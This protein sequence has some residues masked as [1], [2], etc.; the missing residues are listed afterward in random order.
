MKNK[1]PLLAV[2]LWVLCVQF[3]FAQSRTISGVVQDSETGESLPGVAVLEKGTQNGTATNFDG[4]FELTV[5]G[6]NVTLVFKSIGMEDKEVVLGTEDYIIVKMKESSESLDEVVVTAL[7]VSKEKRSLGYTAATVSSDEITEGGDRSPLNSMQGK[8]AGVNISSASSSP[9]SS[10]RI[11]IRGLQSISQNNQP[12]FVIDG[13]PIFNNSSNINSLNNGADFGNG[14]NA[15]NPEDIENIS[16]LKG[17]SATA[18][19]G[20]RAAN[21]VVLITTKKGKTAPAGKKNFGISYAGNVTFSD[22]YILPTFQEDFGQGWDG[23]HLLGENGSWGPKYDGQERVWGNVVDNSQLLKPFVHLPDNVRDFF[24]TGVS[25]QNSISFNGG[26]EKGSYYVSFSNTKSDGIYPTDVDSYNRNTVALRGSR[27]EGLFNFSGSFN[28]TDTRS[29]FVPT[30]QGP[31]VYNNIMQIPRDISIVDMEDYTNKFYNI[32]NYFTPYGVTNPYYTLN[33]FGSKFRGSKFFGGLETSVELTDWLTGTYRFGFDYATDNYNIWEA[34]IDASPGSPNDGTSTEDAGSVRERLYTQRQLN[35]DLILTTKKFSLTERLKVDFLAGL[36]VNERLYTDV[37]AFVND[38]TIPGFYD[39]SNSPNQPSVPEDKSNL[40]IGIED[41]SIRRYGGVYGQAGFDYKNMI[42]LNLTARYDKSSTLPEENNGFLYGGANA[43]FVVTD[44]LNVRSK[45]WNYGKIRVGYGSTGNDA[46]PYI[47]RSYFVQKSVDVPFRDFSFPVGGVNAFSLSNRLGSPDLQPE[48]TKEFEIGGEFRFF[49]RLTVD[50][51][52]YKRVTTDLILDVPIDG[53]SGYTVQ[54]KNVGE[55]QNQGIEALITLD[56]LKKDDVGGL[57]WSVS[58]NYSNNDNELISLNNGLDK[59]S[60]GGLS[61]IGFFAVPGQPLG[62]YEYSVPETEPGTGNIVVDANGVPVASTTKRLEGNAQYDYILGLTNR[63]GYKGITL[64]A[65]V[66]I[67]QGGLMF[68]RTADI[69]NFTG[70]GVKTTFNDRKPWIVP[71]SVQKVEGDDGVTRYIENT[72]AI[73]QQ[74]QD[75]YYRADALDSE[76]LI[77]KSYV[78][79]REVVLGYRIPQKLLNNTAFASLSVSIFGRNLL[80][81][82]PVDNQFVDPETTT[83][84]NGIEADFGE[85][86]ANPSARTYGVGLKA[87]F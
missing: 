53:A 5:S 82:R 41:E 54:T 8:V 19:Y 31:T 64:A 44:L 39:I 55:I 32:D 85:F 47:T 25:Y 86:S 11:V 13:V 2:L 7:G 52:Y 16:I 65:T 38:L 71:N 18:L 20:S 76:Y 12:L 34:V 78:K 77:D 23:T 50:L 51:T 81:W 27:K 61:T 4:K 45:Y 22:V 73:D 75:D 87:S 15:I 33:E 80:M 29:S 58:A 10:S 36:N 57:T 83:F 49:T 62:V 70:N 84:G 67:R 46:A 14:A 59:V 37:D 74:H 17:A 9:G 60:L 79:L 63:L 42:F 72:T 66:D 56:I 30:G 40:G 21:G 43:S 68:S 3:S 6:S 26:D 35:H 24:E 28:F 48:I 1:A 69:N